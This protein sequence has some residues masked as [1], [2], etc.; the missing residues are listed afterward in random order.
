MSAF[1]LDTITIGAIKPRSLSRIDPA[2]ALHRR[3]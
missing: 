3:P 2:A 1:Q